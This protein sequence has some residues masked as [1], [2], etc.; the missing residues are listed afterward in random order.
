M[1]FPSGQ[2]PGYGN[3]PIP[4]WSDRQ[5]IYIVD[6]GSFD[7]QSQRSLIQR[8]DLATLDVSTIAGSGSQVGYVD[9]AG[10]FA[11]FN[12]PTG[13]WGD[14]THLFVA[15][16]ENRAIRQIDLATNQVSTLAGFP[17]SRPFPDASPPIVDGP[18]SMARFTMP[19]RIWGDGTYLYVTDFFV[20]R[21]VTIAT[22]EVTTLAGSP[23]GYRRR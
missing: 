21:Q 17:E 20:I 6:N 18:A 23:W 7:P 12:H 15:D 5:A 1:N 4:I 2:F 16:N 10:V 9:G 14:G 8:I 13:L 19:T 11:R 22:G 3:R